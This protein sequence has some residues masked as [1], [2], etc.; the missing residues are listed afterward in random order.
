MTT[1]RS[2]PHYSYDDY[3]PT[4]GITCPICDSPCGSLQNLNKASNSLMT[5]GSHNEEDTKGAFLS[6][7]TNA[8]K[9]VQTSL[10]AGGRSLQNLHLKSSHPVFFASDNER[11]AGEFI[12]KEH[13]HKETGNDTCYLPGCTRL[14]GKS[15]AGKQHCRQPTGVLNSPASSLRSISLERSESSS[16][17]D[18]LGSLRTPRSPLVSSSN[19]ILSM[20]LKYREGEQTVAS[21]EDDKTV[22]KCPLCIR[23]TKREESMRPLPIFHL[24]QQLSVTRNTIEKQL[25]KFHE[26][27]LVLGH[28]KSVYQTQET[29]Q[30]AAH[31]RKSLLDNFALYDSLSKSIRSLPATTAPLKRLQ[32]NVGA[33]A[34][35]YLQR[36]MLPLQ[37]LPRLLNTHKNPS[38]QTSPGK[39]TLA[40]S[41]AS[42]P[43]ERQTQLHAYREQYALVEGFIQ[44]AQQN[45]KYD[46]VKI[47]KGSLEEL[48]AEMDALEAHS[49][50]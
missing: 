14:V 22:L 34:S 31:I 24:Y 29:H 41:K 5:R 28:E 8:H 17:K 15:G 4:D 40:E 10:G 35:M 13:W 11:Q 7:F 44:D 25:P 27:I 1:S 47:L 3:V 39:Q 46:D 49:T 37:M 18:S 48:R 9:R 12:S 6:W 42:D 33:A 32:A 2:L 50:A 23:K 26:M 30:T 43:Q 19:S 36:N 21:W 45:R 38:S 20:K 16:S